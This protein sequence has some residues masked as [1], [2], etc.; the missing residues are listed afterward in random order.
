MRDECRTAGTFLIEKPT[1]VLLMIREL[2]KAKPE[3][4]S[5]ESDA[6]YTRVLEI[7][8]EF[9]SQ[10]LVEKKPGER[11]PVIELTPMGEALAE[12]LGDIDRKLKRWPGFNGRRAGVTGREI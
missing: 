11:S 2:K 10:G 1:K 6:N 12:N 5:I 4:I 3:E 7:L 8:R 9:E